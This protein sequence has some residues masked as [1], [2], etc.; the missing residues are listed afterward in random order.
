MLI[1]ARRPRSLNALDPTIRVYGKDLVALVYHENGPSP[2]RARRLFNLQNRVKPV[3]N[4]HPILPNRDETDLN[5]SSR[6]RSL[7]SAL[8]TALRD[9]PYPFPAPFE[10]L[11]LRV[12]PH[13]ERPEA[14]RKRGGNP[15]P[16]MRLG[17][18]W[19]VEVSFSRRR[20][21]SGRSER[22]QLVRECWLDD[23]RRASTSGMPAV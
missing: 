14:W 22:Q 15:L 7:R 3:E 1:P 9:A 12:F 17:T 10:S 16:C 19:A 21:P 6:V 8:A 11:S 18:D 2:E 23:E 5:D 20:G 13:P 4:R